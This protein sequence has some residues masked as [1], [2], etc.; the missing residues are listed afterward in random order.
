MDPIAVLAQ[1]AAE[2]PAGDLPGAALSSA[3]DLFVDTLGCILAGSSAE[4]ID[5]VR[6]QYLS[7]GG[8]P[9]STLLPFGD[10]INPPGAAFVNSVSAHA[11]DYDDTHDAAVSH[12]CVTLVPA[13]LAVAEARGHGVGALPNADGVPVSGEEFAAALA[14]GLEIGT[15]LGLAF[16]PY[17]HTGWL[18]TTMWGPFSAAAGCGRLLHLD[19]YQMRHALGI[20]YAQVHGNRQ[21]LLDGTLTKRVQPAFSAV[22]GVQAACLAARGITGAEN[23]VDGTFGLPA[24]YTDG[25]ADRDCL[26][27]GLGS[28]YD[29]LD[30]SIKPFPCCRCTHAIIDGA[31]RIRQEH[32]PTAGEIV[33]GH[34]L[35]PP[36]AMGQ[37]GNPFELRDNPTV[38]AQF[39]A[40]Y[41][42][43]HT[44]IHGPPGLDAFDAGNIRADADVIALARKFKA[45]SFEPGNSGLVP[46][47]IEVEMRDGRKHHVRIEKIKGSR[48]Y[49]LSDHEKRRK[50]QDC[51]AHATTSLSEATS[52][53]LH[54]FLLSGMDCDDMREIVDACCRR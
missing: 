7:W 17:L 20:A 36:N 35:L 5:G 24:L 6:R 45:Q 50:F 12:G 53:K 23:V 40:P 22:A 3:W 32:A 49:P 33:H 43:A 42:A 29:F 41:T 38:D 8:A 21:A 54:D 14:V 28:R 26:T 10:R 44:L 2:K 51:A 30:T 31:D 15:R 47:E 19:S 37:V 4:G 16:I 48:D 27:V 1:F 13:C 9:V 39:S 25:Q 46:A 18:P 11:R 52:S 34:I